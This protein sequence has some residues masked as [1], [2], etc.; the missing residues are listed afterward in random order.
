[1]LTRRRKYNSSL[2]CEVDISSIEIQNAS[3]FLD[4]VEIEHS[5]THDMIT[6]QDLKQAKVT[7]I[8]HKYKF[9]S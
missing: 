1:M 3:L 4:T 2:S 7:N 6:R 8:F 9:L 5:P